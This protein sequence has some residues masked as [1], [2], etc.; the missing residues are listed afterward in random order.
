MS[1]QKV[2]SRVCMV[3]LSVGL[4]SSSC[5]TAPGSRCII[6]VKEG[7]KADVKSIL[8]GGSAANA[9]W[10]SGNV[11]AFRETQSRAGGAIGK[12][13]EVYQIDEQNNLQKIGDF[14]LNLSDNDLL[15][16]YGKDCG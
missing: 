4:L 14:D 1:S 10:R 8:M 16:K 12:A 11:V 3:L 5:G 9:G 7:G 15:N 6:I 2:L 13:G